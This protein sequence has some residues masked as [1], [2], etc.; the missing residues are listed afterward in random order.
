MSY[1][2]LKW[3]EPL[4]AARTPVRWEEAVTRQF[5]PGTPGPPIE[6][7]EIFKFSD[8]FHRRRSNTP[9]KLPAMP[10]AGFAPELDE[11]MAERKMLMT[12]KRR[13]SSLAPRAP[14][15]PSKK[16]KP[17]LGPPLRVPRK[18]KKKTKPDLGPPLRVPRRRWTT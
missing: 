17:D 11:I 5:T 4:P 9:T 3:L 8:Q 6:P 18:K 13:T 15:K 10:L 7:W 2:P 12:P 14:R 1:T 16:P